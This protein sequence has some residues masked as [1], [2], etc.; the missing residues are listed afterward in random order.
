[1]RRAPLVVLLALALPLAASTAADVARADAPQ[2]PAPQAASAQDTAAAVAKVQAFYDKTQTFTSDFT[3]EFWVKAYNQKKQ[4]KGK[5]T[6]Q[7]PGN[8]F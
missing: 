1:M 4:S 5:V 2:A 8:E 7:K 6:I 3:Q